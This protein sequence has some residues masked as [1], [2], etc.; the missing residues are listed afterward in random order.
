M[1][2]IGTCDVDNFFPAFVAKI[3]QAELDYHIFGIFFIQLLD[4]KMLSLLQCRVAKA[5]TLLTIQAKI[6]RS[7][8]VRQAESLDDELKNVA[9]AQFSPATRPPSGQPPY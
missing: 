8:S 5:K 2:T 6:E 7:R 4:I 9:A 3:V 1:M